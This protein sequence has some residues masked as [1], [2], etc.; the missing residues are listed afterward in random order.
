[1]VI[2]FFGPIIVTMNT[3]LGRHIDSDS[4]LVVAT[5]MLAEQAL[6]RVS[7]YSTTLT[8]E[9]SIHPHQIL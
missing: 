3:I 2:L 6:N 9:E 1:M 4:V 8:T 7:T 5:T